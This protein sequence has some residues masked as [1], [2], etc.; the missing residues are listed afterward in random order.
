MPP[1]QK[2]TTP[3]PLPV[4]RVVAGEVVDRAAHVAAGAIGRHAVHQLRG[5]VHLVVPGELDR[6]RDPCASATNPAARAVRHLFDP[7]SSPHH[8]W[9]TRMPG[10]GRSPA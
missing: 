6:D 9:I 2:P 3:M 4:T 10:P 8:S 7:E 5:L 1:M